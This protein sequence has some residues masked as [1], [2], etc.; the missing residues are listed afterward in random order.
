MLTKDPQHVLGR[1]PKTIH[2]PVRE[3]DSVQLGRYLDYCSELLAIISK[4]AA[5]YAQEFS[6]PVA[7]KG[8]DEIENLTSGM[9]LKVWQKMALLPQFE[10]MARRDR[11]APS[12]STGP[13][14]EAPE[15][16]VPDFGGESVA[17]TGT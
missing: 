3:M 4:V 8:V 15:P 5:L 9:Q 12:V 2:S 14:P 13:V 6:D 1:I 17:K 11:I 16:S 10:K 7:L